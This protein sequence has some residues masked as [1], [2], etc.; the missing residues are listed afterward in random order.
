MDTQENTDRAMDVPE[1]ETG[2]PAI[3]IAVWSTFDDHGRHVEAW[4]PWKSSSRCYMVVYTRVDA[5]SVHFPPIAFLTA[6]SQARIVCILNKCENPNLDLTPPALPSLY[7]C[8]VTCRRCLLAFG[9][10][11]STKLIA[12]PERPGGTSLQFTAKNH[13]SSRPSM[14]PRV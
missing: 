6:E 1:L 5:F 10:S 12:P 9:L 8:L 13:R 2:C 7:P 4:K 14:I 11:S 3:G